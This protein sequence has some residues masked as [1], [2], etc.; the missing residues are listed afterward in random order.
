[1]IGLE[2]A[3]ELVTFINCSF[4]LPRR[5]RAGPITAFPTPPP[6]RASPPVPSGF[7]FAAIRRASSR[8]SNFA[9]EPR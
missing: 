6:P 2:V 8:V 5:K 7:I 1:V 4:E 3:P 9:A